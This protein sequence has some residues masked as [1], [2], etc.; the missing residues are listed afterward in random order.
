MRIR[1][2]KHYYIP[3]L[4]CLLLL[5]CKTGTINP[6]KPASPHEQYQ[7]KLT[8][9]GFDKTAAG[10]AWLNASET[11]L[12]KPSQI[13]LPFKER[14]YFAAENIPAIAYTFNATKGQKISISIAQKPVENFRIYVDLFSLENQKVKPL[15]FLDTV[16]TTIEYDIDDTGNYLV[17]L[18]PE[19]L[20]NGEYTLEINYGPSLNYPVKTSSR[21]NI[22][23]FWGAGRDANTRKHEGIDIFAARLTP[24]IAAAE[25]TVTR[26][27]ENNLGGKVVWMRPTGKN[28]TLYYAH[29]DKQ[30][31]VEGQQVSSGDTLGLMGNTGNAKTTAP[32]LHFGIYASGGAVDPLPFVNPVVKP[33]PEISASTANL[34][35]TMRTNRS[36]DVFSSAENGAAKVASLPSNSIVSVHAASRNW[37][38]IEM[39]DGTTGYLQSNRLMAIAKPVRAIKINSDEQMVFDKPDT[40]A[41]RKA[42]IPVNTTAEILGYSGN[43][44]LIKGPDDTVG[45]IKSR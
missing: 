36:T 20:T 39:P 10:M 31:A 3:V 42:T 4:S 22:Q 17:R 14:G 27:N 21:N 12:Q 26:V 2:F 34:N 29:L 5:S 13:K 9:T 7:R 8:S 11:S 15:A 28:Y 41:A 35:A 37:Y 23:S 1:Q 38:R 45:W 18:Q 30:I 19:L 6:F 25:G 16:K 40:T 24:V 44:A 43:F 32:H 33:L